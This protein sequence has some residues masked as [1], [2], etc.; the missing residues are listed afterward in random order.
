MKRSA[1][2]V[3]RLAAFVSLGALAIGLTGGCRTLQKAAQ[4]DP[5]KCERD[6]KC[7]KKRGRTM[8]CSMQCN[9]DPAC[10][11]RC[12]QVRSANGPLGH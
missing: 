6:A 8:D 12:E 11:D 9:D 4:D 2:V 5:L 10:M 1:A 3:V 7:D